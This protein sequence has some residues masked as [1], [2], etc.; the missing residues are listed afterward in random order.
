MII[1]HTAYFNHTLYLWGEKSF[2]AKAL[3]SSLK[4]R[5]V[6]TTPPHP[7]ALEKKEILK[8]LLQGGIQIASAGKSFARMKVHLPSQHGQPFPS[9][10][11]IG[12]PSA[13]DSNSPLKPW[14]VWAHV[15]KDDAIKQLFLQGSGKTLLAPGLGLGR[16]LLFFAKVFRFATGLVASQQFLPTL[17]KQGEKYSARWE[18]VYF[19]N[20]SRQIEKMAREMPAATQCMT[21]N[22]MAA[23]PRFIPQQTIKL[24]IDQMTGQLVRSSMAESP[25]RSIQRKGSLHDQ[26]MSGLV[27]KES[28]LSGNKKEIEKLQNQIDH[29]SQ[30]ILIVANSPLRLVFRLE[31][32]AAQAESII[33]SFL[34]P[35]RERWTVRFMLE[36]FDNPAVLSSVAEAWQGSLSLKLPDSFHIKE[37]LYSGLGQAARLCPP[38]EQSLKIP[39]PSTFS[40]DSG[41]TYKFITE[42]ARSLEGA[43]LG[44]L[45]PDWWGRKKSRLRLKVNAL[46][47]SSPYRPKGYSALN[48][49]ITFHWEVVLGKQPLVLHELENL[50][51]LNSPL[52]KVRGQWVEVTSD[53][54]GKGKSFWRKGV[55]EATLGEIVRLAL[56]GGEIEGLEFGEVKASGWVGELLRQLE[57]LSAFQEQPLPEGFTGQ[58]RNY[59]TRGYSWLSFLRQFGFGACLADDMGLG[60][61]VQTLA[62][63]QQNRNMD[64]ERPVLLI[65]PTSVVNNWQREAN[66]FAPH[67]PVYIHHGLERKKAQTLIEEIKKQGLVITSYAL[68]QMDLTHLQKVNW[69][70]L[71][72]DEAQNIKNALTGQAEAARSL[73]ADFR[74]ALTGTPVENHV[75][76]LWSIMEFLN[77]NF[78][79]TAS[80][81]KQNFFIPIHAGKN[82]EA[83]TRLKRLTSPFILRRLKT[84]KSILADLPEKQEI[85]VYCPLTKEQAQ[86]YAA[87]GKAA[88]RKLAKTAGIQR[89]G[90]ILATFSKLKQICNHPLQYLKDRSKITGRSG[91]LNRL[92]EMLEEILE[93]KERVLIF[94][95]FTG[96]GEILKTYI[97]ENFGQAVFFLHGGTPKSQRDQLV[98]RF[99]KGEVQVFILSLKAGGTG[100]TLTAANHV[101]HYDRWWNPAVEN[102]ATDRAFRIGQTRDVQVHKFICAGT[103]EE[104]I[105]AMIESKKGLAEQ[106]IGTGE[107]WLT[108]LSNAELKNIFTLRTEVVTE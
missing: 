100:L 19:W 86:L 25:S 84:D 64:P 102:Q 30:P 45:F 29:W 38:L 67:L 7:F 101:I 47:R 108:E 46:I 94:S 21:S 31:E 83:S 22:E 35:G 1:F 20:E 43:G 24:F 6:K 44:V 55:G 107:G 53:E 4:Y 57:G 91:K 82:Q 48:E 105:D 59:Q 9:D 72:L 99:Q 37:F 11:L 15:L 23:P 92:T 8:A 76:D 93:A 54:I 33:Q 56:G 58:L 66:R 52:V 62:L 16:D 5:S 75:G 32:P 10:S 42:D 87:V 103:L 71:I 40:L 78:L 50:E 13:L 17:E 39:N 85:K 36:S 95:Q 12:E 34:P 14:L 28:F 69:S 27:K 74:I 65:C 68:L 77:P 51:K 89:K 70:G 90:I 73:S 98:D 18:P 3:A 104:K 88:E 96:M 106:V 80:I 60:K 63:L 41:S 26:W 81:F 79:G 49:K 61:T 2:E 97:Q